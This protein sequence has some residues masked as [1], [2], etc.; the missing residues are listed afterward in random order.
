[1]NLTRVVGDLPGAHFGFKVDKPSL[2]LVE[3]ISDLVHFSPCGWSARFLKH[4]RALS[5][6]QMSCWQTVFKTVTTLE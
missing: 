5:I 4:V 6:A 3:V 2:E 1:M